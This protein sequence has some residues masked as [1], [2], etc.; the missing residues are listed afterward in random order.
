MSLHGN[1]IVCIYN[2]TM[3]Q[4]VWGVGGGIGGVQLEH[5]SVFM[6]EGLTEVCG[7]VLVA[8]M[9]A[10]VHGRGVHLY[11]VQTWSRTAC[12]CFLFISLMYQA[13]SVM[14]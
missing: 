8:I 3:P 4:T 12:S 9:Y 13:T 11:P 5:A 2:A 14:V 1:G 7:C 6:F 10:F